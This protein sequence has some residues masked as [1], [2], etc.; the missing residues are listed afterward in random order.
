MSTEIGVVNRVGGWLMV[1]GSAAGL[2]VALVD[3]LAPDNGIGGS[4]GALLVV[5]S[6][7][8]ILLASLV[9]TFAVVGRRWLRVVIECLLGL[10]IL[11]TGFAAYMLEANAL[12]GL[13]GVAV[14]G[15]A[16]HLIAVPG[17]TRRA[18]GMRAGV[19]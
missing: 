17:R 6:S 2:A 12:L 1:A 4:G 19:A 13:M 16:G 9:V 5:V 7:A 14:V 11:G 10:G 15:W 8:L 18:A 3:F